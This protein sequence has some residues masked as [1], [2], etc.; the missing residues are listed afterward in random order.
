[1]RNSSKDHLIQ[2]LKKSVGFTLIEMLIVVAI[3]AILVAVA[4]PIVSTVLDK[5][6]RATDAA[7]ER[8]LKA[9]MAIAYLSD[10]YVDTKSATEAYA[11]YK[12]DV[13]NGK[14]V[15]FPM[16]TQTITK[17]GYGQC[18]D[19]KGMDLLVRIYFKESTGKNGEKME[20]GS[21]EIFWD[22]KNHKINSYND[23]KA[24][25]LDSTTL[26]SSD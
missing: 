18:S 14:L 23:K 4:I 7:N 2:K 8:S 1:M 26:V 6:K 10:D 25:N 9:L 21:Y 12:F 3:I 19:H 24:F 5:T 15:A 11:T 13:E 20:P 17:Y 16:G 22:T